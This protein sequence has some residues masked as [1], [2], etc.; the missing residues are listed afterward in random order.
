MRTL[1]TNQDFKNIMKIIFNGN[2]DLYKASNG[3]IVYQNTNSE[4]IT[5]IDEE[6]QEQE[7]VDLAEYL[8]IKF[9][10]WKNRLV[11]TNRREIFFDE[12]SDALDF[13]NKE[14]YGLIE[15]VDEEAT[16]SQ[17]I[18]S[19]TKSGKITFLIS[20]DK[21]AN[22]DYYLSKI[23]NNYL[24]NPQEIENS[25]GEKIKAYF[26][27]S[28]L[29]YDEEPEMTPIGEC[30]VVS[31]NFSMTYL[32]NALAY[33]DT[34]I[35]ISLDEENNYY[36]IPITKMTWQNIFSSMSMPMY[37]RPD[38]TGSLASSISCVKSIT[39]YDFNKELTLAFNDLMWKCGCVR[40]DGEDSKTQDVNIPVYV[41]I[42]SNGHTYVYK[43][44]IDNM[45]KVISNS[46]FNI[47]S[48]TLKGYAKL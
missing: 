28:P 45:Q 30:V 7:E 3:K 31:C 40:Y 24:G 37:S 46:D 22:L 35:E 12:W 21:V 36:E 15:I 20:S 16:A 23:R 1:F 32:T 10:S 41:K 13:D 42:T 14:G 38:L 2:L 11:E 29:V 34:K 8:N 6:T 5:L 4:K 33:N 19:A 17:D 18:D 47:S 43:D 44:M 39:F 9:Y 27:F 48:I 26:I 25:F